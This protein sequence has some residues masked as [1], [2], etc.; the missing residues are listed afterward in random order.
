[1]KELGYFTNQVC[2]KITFPVDCGM[3]L[4]FLLCTSKSNRLHVEREPDTVAESSRS[5]YDYVHAVRISKQ[6]NEYTETM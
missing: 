2:V 3:P 1:M 4:S 5:L 6:Q